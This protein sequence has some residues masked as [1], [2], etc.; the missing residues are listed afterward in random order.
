MSEITL[1]IRLS[2][3]DKTTVEID[4]SSTVLVLKQKIEAKLNVAADRQRLIYKG[5]VLKDDVTLEFY[6]IQHEHTVHMVKGAGA[7]GPNGNTTSSS[8]VQS[9]SVAAAST[10]PAPVSASAPNTVGAFG[11]NPFGAPAVNPFGGVFGTANTNNNNNNNNAALN[12]MMMNPALLN[13]PQA[14]QEQLMRNPEM[15]NS[16]MNSP[17]M[18]NLMNDPETIRMMMNSNPQ[19]Q[20]MMESNPQLRQVMND[21]AMLR[22]SMEMMRNP[23]AMQQAMRSQD[24]QISQ[25]ENHPLGFNA[26][27]RMQEDIADPLM[28]AAAEGGAVSNSDTNPNA[29]AQ[30]QQQSTTPNTDALPNPWG[31]PA[32]PA[33]TYG[34]MGAGGLSNP[35]AAMGGGAGSSGLGGAGMGMDPNQM[36]AMMSNP[37]MQQQMQSMLSNPAMLQQLA[38][39][40][41]AL[42]PMLQDPQFRAM[43]TSP[44][45]LAQMSNPAT[46]QSALRMQQQGGG[47]GGGLG[48][49]GGMPPAPAN[50]PAMGGMDFGS[51]FAPAAPA[52][53]APTAAVPA[54]VVPPAQRYAAELTQL[55]NMGFVDDERSLRVLA[56]CNGNVNVAVERLLG[57]N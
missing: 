27:R 34:D 56:S 1:T 55:Q 49:F 12:A 43:L 5:R 37:F 13:N 54:V 16:L 30:Q 29:T 15:M 50:N 33:P 53:P 46:I 19:L 40:N 35:F 25:L 31:A 23:H 36:A 32:A 26:L 41:P 45:M 51:L 52:V 21:P 3:A 20:R 7:A 4:V 17:M 2:N 18:E 44:A 6:G 22:Q 8:A 39:A 28:Q 10:T 47:M 48:M 38:A 14:M 42:G 9:T 24:L 11:A 57:G